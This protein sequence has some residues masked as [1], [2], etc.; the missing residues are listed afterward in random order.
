ML[1]KL[2]SCAME[3]EQKRIS[4]IPITEISEILQLEGVSSKQLAQEILAWPLRIFVL[5]SQDKLRM[6][7]RNGSAISQQIINYL[8]Y[9]FRG[10]GAC[11]G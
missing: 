4:V 8:R 1:S 9:N 10:M 11:G 6:W 7:V 5:M 3:H 2:I